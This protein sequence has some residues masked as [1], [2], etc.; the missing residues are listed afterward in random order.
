MSAFQTTL[1]KL[2]SSLTICSLAASGQYKAEL[3][4]APPADVAPAIVQTLEK[5]GFRITENGTLY[6]EVWFRS[7]LPRSTAPAGKNV[8]L[9]GIPIG[10]L[11]GVI[12]FQAS[13]SDRLGQAIAAGSYTLRYVNMP[14]NSDHE[15]SAPQRDFLFLAPAANESDPESIPKYDNLVELSRKA[16][17]SKHPAVLSIWKARSDATGFGQQGDDWVL[18]TKLGDTAI[19]LVLIG[20]AGPH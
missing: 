7:H 8:T 17:L 10:A 19:E 4:A 20:T 13:G 15:G 12:R 16:S 1:L 6:C 3:A 11:V 2:L 5:T 14:A 9:P 18:Q